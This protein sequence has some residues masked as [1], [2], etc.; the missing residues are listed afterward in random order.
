MKKNKNTFVVITLVLFMIVAAL[1][2]AATNIFVLEEKEPAQA[3][4]YSKG[5]NATISAISK[6]DGSVTISLTDSTNDEYR[7]YCGGACTRQ[8]YRPQLTFTGTAAYLYR[9]G[10][11][12]IKMFCEYKSPLSF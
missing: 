6:G 3:A 5:K 2:F 8:Y 9:N 7:L 12:T 11:L 10:A 1:L 4:T